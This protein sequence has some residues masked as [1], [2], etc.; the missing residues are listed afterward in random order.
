MRVI[1]ICGAR[2]NFMKI[3]PLMEAYRAEPG[4]RAAAGP[5]RPALRREDERP[6]LRRAGIPEPD[7]NL[8]VGSGSHAVQTAEIMKRVRAG[9][10]G[11]QARR[12]AGRRRREQHDRL[13]PG[14]REAGR[15]AGPRRG[16]PAQLRP[17]HARGDQP[18]P[19]RRD[20]RPAVRAREPSG[21]ENLRREGVADEK[22]HLVGNVMIDTLLKQ[23]RARPRHRTILDGP[24]PDARRL[25]RADAAPAEQRGRPGGLRPD[26]STR[27]EVIQQDL[28][29][30]FPI[31]P[32][33]RNNLADAGL[34][35]AC[36]GHEATCRLIDP[37]GYL[38]FLKLTAN[39]RRRADRLRRHPGGDDDPGG[40]LPDAA[41]E[42]RA[43][44]HR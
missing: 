20:Q 40:A 44:G 29:I 18:P 16:R 24:G 4:H 42:H 12:G 36:R 27:L 26:C 13:R 19:H 14:G 5:H 11:A 30:V 10:A 22:V 15:Q 33:T 43:A 6:V 21:V 39:A 9:R 8:G 3:A 37:P 23:P 41:G 25:R 2:P 1:N 31:H 35:A 32:R 38:D 28:P 7:I 17:H 34:A